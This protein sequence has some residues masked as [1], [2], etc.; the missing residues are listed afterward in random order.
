MDIRSL[1]IL[2][3]V[4]FV[5]LR[6]LKYPHYG[7][8][9]LMWVGYMNPH[10]LVPW[11]I[12]YSMP[13]AAFAFVVTVIGY[14]MMKDKEKPAI[15]QA[16]MILA[17]FWV[18]CGICTIYAIN[19]EA[20]LEEYIRYTK[21]LLSTL[22]F[23]MIIRSENHIK[24]AV[25]VIALSIGFYGIKGG[26]FSILTGGQH[27][28]WG[29]VQSFIEGNNE[30]ALALLMVLPLFY[31]LYQYASH[32][33]I[34]YATAAA[35]L[36]CVI[37]VVTSYSRGAFLALGVTI[38][39]LW[40]KSSK[41]LPLAIIGFVVLLSFVP[42]IPDHWY[43]RMETI[44]TYEQD[45]SA[46]GRIN[47]WHVAINIASDRITSG[48][49]NHWGSETFLLYAPNPTD[50]H[51]SHSIYFEVLGEQGYIG[52]VIFLIF[53][54]TIWRTCSH[55]IRK[56]KSNSSLSWCGD[57]SKMLQVS[58]VA[59]CSGGAFLGLAY[60]DLPYH[61]FALSVVTSLYIKRYEHAEYASENN[62]EHK[63]A[64]RPLRAKYEYR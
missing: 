33:A 18:W 1:A 23:L 53:L 41:K 14:L 30:I 59:Y 25:W 32:K 61:I 5:G 35:M 50:I 49:F 43:E 3:V 29:P 63:G 17:L 58:L 19:Q 21:I 12:V 47:A 11:G 44:Q 26:M 6:A 20:A 54:L 27:R 52:L 7:V 8:Y 64:H 31:F 28:V 37:S 38:L 57:L 51:D 36:L 48:G 45:G 40:S 39:F 15:P 10:R 55:N 46:M 56:S 62:A 34:K 22:L 4:A 16:F 9:L 2:A 24:A 42:F 13:I 60:W